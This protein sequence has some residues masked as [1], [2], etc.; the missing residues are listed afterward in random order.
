MSNR[1][2]N[3][4]KDILYDLYINQQMTSNEIAKLFGCTTK[5]VRNNLYKF[6]IPVRQNGEAVKL[7]RSKWSKE[8]EKNRTRKYLTTI[9]NKTPEER[10]QMTFN[11]R[12][13]C[14]SPDSLAKSRETK[15][16]HQSFRKSQSEDSFYSKLLIY[17]D[18]DDIVRGYIDKER[19]P[20]NCDFYIKSK[21]L[22]IEYQGHQTH[23][24]KPYNELDLDCLYEVEELERHGFSTL[25][26]TKRDPDKLRKA[27]ENKINLLLIYPKYNAYF[28][29]DGKIQNLGK[30][31]EINI[32]DID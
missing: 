30:S 4:T 20:F 32:N 27:Q 24:T 26:Y 21:D 7:E 1:K 28:I 13:K 10:N 31:N 2:I 17:Y 6:G 23:G 16:S 29:K 15:L 19:Y 3:T 25:T 22:F 5:T 14:N 12:L 11:A 8:K 18:K 9:Y